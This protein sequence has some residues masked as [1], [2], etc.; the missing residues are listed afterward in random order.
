MANEA[1]VSSAGE[2]VMTEM[3]S[4][5]I[6]R[7]AYT[8]TK[9]KP[10]V[11]FA[12]IEGQPTRT[13]EFPKSPLLTASAL[14]EGVDLANTP[15][16]PTSVTV[17]AAEVGLLIT[18][19]DVLM[20]ASIVGLEYYVEQLGLALATKE[21]LDIAANASSFTASVGSSTVD[22]TETNFLDARYTLANGN[23][24]GPF[25]AG[26]HPIQLR[27]LQVDIAA[28]SGAIWGASDGPAA[29]LRF[30][31]AAFYGVVCVSSTNV[32]TANAGADR[33]GFMAPIGQGCGIAYLA[34][35]G[36]AI[37]A[38]RDASLRA[39]ELVAT[40][41]YGTGCINVA[42]NGGVQIVTDA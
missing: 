28:S 2:F 19:T 36:P 14:S 39:T 1:T 33:N 42:A 3:I 18:P 37:E 38:Q 22:L 21:D 11:H 26:L 4:E 16:N 23:A 41:D 24:M 15:F 27:D 40:C 6:I 35:R 32:P 9:F 8:G 34:K 30:E 7:A 29:E 20:G 10:F 12:S 5:M 31:M 25:W 13:K 17:T